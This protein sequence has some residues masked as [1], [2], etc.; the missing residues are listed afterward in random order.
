MALGDKFRSQFQVVIYLPVKDDPYCLV[1]VGYGLATSR[2]INDTES[3]HANADRSGHVVALVIGPPVGHGPIHLL[4]L[5]TFR[6][7][8]GIEQKYA[9]DSAHIDGLIGGF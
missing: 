3:A 9:A 6:F 8:S 2:E 1:L 7:R 4:E 5:V